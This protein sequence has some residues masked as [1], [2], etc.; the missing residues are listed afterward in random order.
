MTCSNYNFFH[1]NF[2][3]KDKLLFISPSSIIKYLSDIDKIYVL[4]NSDELSSDRNV[5]GYNEEG[6]LLWQVE[7][8]YKLHDRNYFTSI[9]FQDNELFAYNKNDV[10]VIIDKLTGKFL[11]TELI[12]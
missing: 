2:Y 1:K 9:Y 12:K 11:N 3:K 4:I 10:E 6:E 5:F 8:M 7:E